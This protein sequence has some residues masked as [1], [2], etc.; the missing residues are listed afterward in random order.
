MIKF[1]TLGSV[2][3]KTHLFTTAN[4]L[5][6][7]RAYPAWNLKLNDYF[8]FSL[9]KRNMPLSKSTETKNPLEI[10]YRDYWRTGDKFE[11]GEFL[12][13]CLCDLFMFEQFKAEIL[14][15]S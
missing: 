1:D 9:V 13:F 10:L 8:D 6:L 7:K 4:F 15:E 5:M 2:I 14:T 12:N 3:S 11:R